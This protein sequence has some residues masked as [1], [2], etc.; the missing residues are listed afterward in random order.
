MRDCQHV[1]HAVGVV[2]QHV[3]AEVIADGAAE[4]TPTL[5]L[6]RLSVD[7]IVGD[8]GSSDL[9]D[10]VGEAGERI[11]RERDAL[12]ER[13]RSPLAHWCVL[14]GDGQGVQ[15]EQLGL[16][17]KP[18]LGKVVVARDGVHHR[19]NDRR[20]KL[21]LQ[22]RRVHR[23]VVAAKPIHRQAVRDERVVAVC[24]GRRVRLQ[25][26]VQRPERAM[27]QVAIG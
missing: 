26:P 22:V 25:H 10:P 11:G 12:V 2:E 8:E 20:R 19:I 3:R 23:R 24:D 9:G 4:G 1:S 14:V 27:A 17:G 7:A 21:V 5:S 16:G 13:D 15:P 18:P 6:A